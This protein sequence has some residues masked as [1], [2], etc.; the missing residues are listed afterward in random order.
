MEGPCGGRCQRSTGEEP[1]HC[2]GLIC[3]FLLALEPQEEQVGGS[4]AISCRS[5]I[6]FFPSS[7]SEVYNWQNRNIFKMYNMMIY[8]CLHCE[9]MPTAKLAHP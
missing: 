3:C 2:L 4:P 6:V 7:F 5:G 8:I 1:G 9:K